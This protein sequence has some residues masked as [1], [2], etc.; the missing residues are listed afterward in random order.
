MKSSYEYQQ[1]FMS[2][3]G[4]LGFVISSQNYFGVRVNCEKL[5]TFKHPKIDYDVKNQF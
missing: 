2:T 3:A 1:L 4:G 5:E